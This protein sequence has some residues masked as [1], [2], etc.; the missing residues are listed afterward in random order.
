MRPRALRW[1]NGD[2]QEPTR[3]QPRGQEGANL[4]FSTI[5][6][7]IALNGFPIGEAVLATSHRF[8]LQALD[9]DRAKNVISDYPDSIRQLV[10]CAL[11]EGRG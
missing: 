8:V 3:H 2:E 7:H 5:Y 10:V 4:I 9:H 11:A 1:A 6:L